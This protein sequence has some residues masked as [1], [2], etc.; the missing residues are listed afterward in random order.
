MQKGPPM[1][2]EDPPIERI[3]GTI[4]AYHRGNEV[5]G[6]GS[7]QREASARTWGCYCIGSGTFGRAERA[8]A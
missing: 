5:L 4:K 6:Q 2:N 1:D 3:G 7:A 8:E